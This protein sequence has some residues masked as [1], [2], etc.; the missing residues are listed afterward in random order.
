M[1]LFR[2]GR[3]DLLPALREWEDGQA[4]YEISGEL[5][6]LH[7][8]KSALLCKADAVASRIAMV[9]ATRQ[10]EVSLKLGALRSFLGGNEL[11]AWVGE[12]GKPLRPP[13]RMTQ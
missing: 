8:I 5:R 3:K 6:R 12:M 1:I 4:A 11:P 7:E 2:I 13:A 9:H 10:E